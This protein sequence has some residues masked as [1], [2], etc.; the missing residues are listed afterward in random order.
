[1]ADLYVE[2]SVTAPGQEYRSR[3]RFLQRLTEDIR[4]PG[5]DMMVAEATVAAE[6]PALVGCIFGYPV[7][8]DGSWWQ[9]LDGEFPQDIEQLTASG[10]VFAITEIVVH[11]HE[12]HRGLAGRLQER[13]LAEH[14]AS[15]GV[16]RVDQTDD[17]GQAAF[18]S[19]GWQ[20]IGQIRDSLG[21]AVQRVLMLPLGERSAAVPDGLA[22]NADTEPP[23]EADAPD[24][25]MR[26]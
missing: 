22:H 17:A 19:W 24:P 12:Q 9:G 8:R 5:F 15:L 18:R 25:G 10:H 20:D 4:R 2:S 1:M 21:S 23:R 16:T 13:L 7:G 3:E 11:P 26:R 14:Q 6:A